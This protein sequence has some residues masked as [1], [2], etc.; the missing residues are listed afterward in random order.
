[1]TA[2]EANPRGIPRA[3]FMDKVEDFV[4]DGEVEGTLRKFQEMIAKYRTMEAHLLQRKQSLESKIPELKKTLDM[5][6]FL[7]SRA[8]EDEPIMTDFEVNDTL[9]VRS[10]INPTESVFL[11]LGANVMLEY[12]TEE[13][14]TLLQDKLTTAKGSL[15]QIL[16]DLE[17]FK[18]ANN[19]DG[20]QL[21]SSS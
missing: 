9:W 6:L 17:F 4:A 5:V 11:W 13:A 14:K 20:G 3:P 10:K 2:I 1:M 7:L 18:G 16:E 15:Q 8:S 12:K 19:N 21:F